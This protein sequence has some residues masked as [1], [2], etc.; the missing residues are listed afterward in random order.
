MKLVSWCTTCMLTHS[1]SSDTCPVVILQ[2]LPKNI[3]L[4]SQK[5]CR[6]FLIWF[7]IFSFLFLIFFWPL[8]LLP[9]P[10]LHPFLWQNWSLKC[11]PSTYTWNCVYNKDFFHHELKHKATK[12]ALTSLLTWPL[13]YRASTS[14]SCTTAMKVP[15]LQ[16][17]RQS[18]PL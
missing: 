15:I 17:C 3:S 18:R 9:G 4:M 11:F 8:K 1:P 13:A 14:C 5:A 7:N 12:R 6:T 16:S 10:L 2:N